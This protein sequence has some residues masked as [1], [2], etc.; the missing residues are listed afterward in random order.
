MGTHEKEIVRRIQSGH[1]AG[2]D[3]SYAK[4]E[5]RPLSGVNLSGATLQHISARGVDLS[6]ANLSGADLS[7]AWLESANLSGANLDGARLS[8]AILKWANLSGATMRGADLRGLALLATR[9]RLEKAGWFGSKKN[10]TV[11][12]EY[13]VDLSIVDTT[14][15]LMGD[16]EKATVVDA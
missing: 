5:H 4:L 14:G 2:A 15:C 8:G 6:G 9:V 16:N 7:N 3:F 12:V 11:T 13:Q 10:A 1:G